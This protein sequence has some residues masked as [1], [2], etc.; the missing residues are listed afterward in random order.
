[1]SIVLR[2]VRTIGVLII[3][4]V[5]AEH[6]HAGPPLALIFTPGNQLAHHESYWLAP[7]T[8]YTMLE[9][10][11]SRE[12][13]VQWFTADGRLKHEVRNADV[14]NPGF[15]RRQDTRGETFT[16]VANPH[17]EV[18]L[19][20]RRDWEGPSGFIAWSP[21]GRVFIHSSRVGEA[22]DEWPRIPTTIEMFIEG[23]RKTLGPYT[24]APRAIQLDPSGALAVH[25]LD[26]RLVLVDRSGR[27]RFQTTA[28]VTPGTRLLGCNDY[29]VLV[30]DMDDTSPIEYYG[31]E[32]GRTSFRKPGGYPAVWIGRDRVLFD[33]A[34][35]SLLLVDCA[36]GGVIWRRH[37]DGERI[38]SGSQAYAVVEP[39]LI[40][41]AAELRPSS[42]AEWPALWLRALELET[43]KLVATWA[44]NQTR[45]AQPRFFEN[46]GRVLFLDGSR[47][48]N[49]D[50]DDIRESRQG[51]SS[52]RPPE[53][54]PPLFEEG[55]AASPLSW[56][57]IQPR[58]Q[59]TAMLFTPRQRI[60]NVDPLP[61]SVNLVDFRDS[62]PYG[63]KERRDVWLA[64]YD[65]V[66]VQI[67][68]TRI[69]IVEHLSA[70]FD[71]TTGDLVCV[72]TDPAPRWI[73]SKQEP[74]DA[75][76]R[77]RESRHSELAPAEYSSLQSTPVD[78]VGALLGSRY[79]ELSTVGQIVL[80]PRFVT[81]QFPARRF[82]GKLIP[83]IPPSNMWIVEV[84][85]FKAD[86]VVGDR[87]EVEC[88]PIAGIPS[89]RHVPA[90]VIG[91]VRNRRDGRFWPAP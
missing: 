39:Y 21:D 70:A 14:D 8:L 9:V 30:G 63:E 20:A 47:L 67:D 16:S 45:G 84:L 71:A 51:W 88:I 83:I 10:G 44:G 53:P 3:T 80:R 17:W 24:G 75:E 23:K 76:A 64:R 62:R 12:T 27:E 55:P 40:T 15:V 90:I 68:S 50:P 65:S 4:L 13:R 46:D 18:F 19:P 91:D 73:R 31:V 34:P 26:G 29:G 86:Q 25:F 41:A 35:D 11:S 66:R 36:K 77:V 38:V 33:S 43:G 85:G 58:K 6:A 87:P 37:H 59:A 57:P 42:D 79:V 28:P 61:T 7:Y 49:V 5:L 72:F 81:A 69:A 74:V 32:G 22:Y 89:D 52:S 56:E 82:E 54:A 2:F 60:A 48:S 1:M 78:I